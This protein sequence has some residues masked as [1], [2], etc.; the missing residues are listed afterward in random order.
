MQKK[1][2]EYDIIIEQD[3]NKVYVAYVPELPGCHTEGDTIEEVMVNISEAM[4]L[5]LEY[6]KNKVKN[7]MKFVEVRKITVPLPSIS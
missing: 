3:E 7:P 6:T 5:Y 2:N 1:V 4:G